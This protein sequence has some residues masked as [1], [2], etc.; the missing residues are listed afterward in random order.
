M[1]GKAPQLPDYKGS[2]ALWLVTAL[3]EAYIRGR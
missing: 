3:G 2:L 1:P